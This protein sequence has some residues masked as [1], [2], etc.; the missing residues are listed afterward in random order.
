MLEKCTQRLDWLGYFYAEDQD[1]GL[2]EYLI[3]KVTNYVKCECNITEIPIELNEY[4]IDN[5]VGEFL[6]D[7]KNTGTLQIDSINLDA[8]PKSI[9]MGDTKIEYAI[10]KTKSPEEQRFDIIIN[11]LMSSKKGLLAHFRRLKW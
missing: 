3:S 4:I 11:N 5:V 10:D 7:R 2:L 8:L 9:Q 6:L 1:K